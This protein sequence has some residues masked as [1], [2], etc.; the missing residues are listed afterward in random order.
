MRYNSR[1]YI[2]YIG[3]DY[4]IVQKFD[5]DPDEKIFGMG[6]YQQANT[7]LRGCILDLQQRN[8]QITVPFMISSK[9]YG[10]LWNNPAVGRV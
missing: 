8:S 10:L 6:Q 4:R 9:G 5:G 3:G 1:E 7:N 2:P